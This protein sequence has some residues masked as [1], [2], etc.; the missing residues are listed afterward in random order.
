MNSIHISSTI[1]IGMKCD[2]KL[3][4]KINP[5]DLVIK[6]IEPLIRGV[7]VLNASILLNNGV[8]HFFDASLIRCDAV[9]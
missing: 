5:F 7:F 1:L 6:P 9:T 8:D 3:I 4:I 2:M